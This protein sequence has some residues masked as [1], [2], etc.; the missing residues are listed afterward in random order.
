MARALIVAA[1]LLGAAA[2]GGAGA[3]NYPDKPIRVVDAYSPGGTSD[4][5]GRILGQKFLESQGQPWIMDNRPGANGIIG[6]EFVAKSPPNGYTLLMF[7]ST[8]TVQ[9]SIYKNL[10]YDVLK[11]F[12]PVVLVSSTANVVVVHPTI[13]VKNVKEFIALAR[14]KPGQLTYA[15]GG[16]GT[17]T[18]MSMELF[19]SMAKLNIRHIPYKGITPGVIDVIGGHVDCAFA[20]MPVALPYIRSGKLRAL[21][22]TSEKRAKA[23]PEIPTVAEAVLPGYDAVNSVGVL[24]PA[25]TPREIVHKLNAEIARILDLP[26][27]RERFAVVGAEAA[28]G[29]PEKFGNYI[30]SEISKWA[31]VVKSSGME[32]QA[33]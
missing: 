21:A 32:V 29:T 16:A 14:A 26:D 3:Q 4:I 22:V 7:T 15:S 25:E 33:W 2:V 17:S 13:P 8:L 30:R 10:P 28:G 11:S 23:T 18:H 5:L 20:T 6:S 24:A 9:P 1:A 19:K 12:V 31:G 27:V